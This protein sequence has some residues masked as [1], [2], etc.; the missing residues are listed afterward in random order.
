MDPMEAGKKAV[1]EHAAAYVKDGMIVG[2][3]SG[4]TAS[5]MITKLGRRVREGLDIR[6]VPTSIKTERLARESG[7]P[8]ADF[9]SAD[10]IDIAIDGA[11]EVDN[12][13]QLLKGG[14]GALLREKIVASAADQLIIIVDETKLVK[15]LGA[16]PLP[17]EVTPFGWEMTAN[18]LKKLGGDPQLR[19]EGGDVCVTNN[20]N[21]ILDCNFREIE[22]PEK[23]HHT[24]KL[25]TGVVETGLFI[26][27][28]DQ[29]IT[30]KQD[31]IE[32][33]KR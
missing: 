15:R 11:D 14:G 18:N 24:L 17:V 6:G 2:L 10:R 27:M 4:S 28:A 26:N 29:V 22:N 12:N 30:A 13:L 19:H 21:Y 31:G 3:G 20:L 7:I 8:L 5:Y 32:I 16:F 25:L 1:G 33:L 23:L 9:S